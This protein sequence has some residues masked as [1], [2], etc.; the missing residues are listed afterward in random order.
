MIIDE[1][2]SR[3]VSGLLFVFADFGAVGD[4]QVV[5]QLNGCYSCV[6]NACFFD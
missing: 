1:N 3:D 5:A 6:I 2:D 4:L